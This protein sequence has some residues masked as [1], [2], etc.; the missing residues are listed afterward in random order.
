MLVG[1]RDEQQ[2]KE[3]VKALNFRLSDDELMQINKAA[4]EFSLAVNG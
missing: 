4:G 3:N 1:A 2:V